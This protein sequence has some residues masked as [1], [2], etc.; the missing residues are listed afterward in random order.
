MAE[1]RRVYCTFCEQRFL[2][3]AVDTCPLC[4]RTGGLVDPSSPVAS[5]QISDSIQKRTREIGWF[6]TYQFVRLVIGGLVCGLLGFALLLWEVAE[7]EVS[8][9]G[10]VRALSISA[11]GFGLVG[12]IVWINA[13]SS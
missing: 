3:T 11:L 2:S 9:W 1:E 8:F 12:I 13:R 4:G 5:R 7:R 6:G 10:V